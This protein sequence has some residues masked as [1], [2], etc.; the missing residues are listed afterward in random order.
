MNAR[1][2]GALALALLSAGL[3]ACATSKDA[4]GRAGEKAPASHP[5]TDDC[6]APRGLWYLHLSDLHLG[7]TV[8]TQAER[9]DTSV[10][11]WRAARDALG[12]WI[13]QSPP[14]FILYTGDLPDHSPDRGRAHTENIQ[15]ALA[16]LEELSGSIPFLYLPGNNDS[17]DWNYATFTSQEGKTPL[18]AS[19]W[20]SGPALHAPVASAGDPRHGYYSAVPVAGLRVVAL[21]TVMFSANYPC[22]YQRGTPG[23]CP[24][25]EQD[26]DAERQLA[27]L[28][29][30][31]HEAA[32]AGQK[33]LL[34][35]HIPPGMDVYSSRRTWREPRWQ[36][37]LLL[38]IAESPAR[39]VGLAYGHTHM[40]ELRRLFDGDGKLELIALSA[41]GITPGHGNNPGF[42][43]VSLGAG[44]EATDA[45]TW[46]ATPDKEGVYEWTADHC[47]RYSEVFG[48]GGQDLRT[49]L[50]ARAKGDLARAM[51]TIYK[52]RNGV[53]DN[54]APGIDVRPAAAVQ[55]VCPA[56]AQC[57]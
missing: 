21:N 30:Q 3:L 19:G 10:P 2:S 6:A 29:G 50:G 24:G 39:V 40:D 1:S 45:L 25:Q 26:R 37:E 42:K 54:T 16:G 41:P 28:K 5:G 38:A 15:E 11:L 23:A 52:V 33:V 17:L 20:L 44:F 57:P 31:L 34:A 7:T 46:Y 47:Y 12:K 43:A 53:A 9:G 27:W 4:A 51:G 13:R 8:E 55:A 18:E 14:A 35:M 56:P 36:D 49:C 32:G 22:H 48:C